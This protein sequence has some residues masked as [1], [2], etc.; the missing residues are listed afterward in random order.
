MTSRHLCAFVALLFPLS[1]AAAT[2]TLSPYGTWV[3]LSAK[4]S[5]SP[6]VFEGLP[7]GLSPD[8]I[9]VR[10]Q[11]ATVTS[12]KVL[13][14]KASSE[15]GNQEVLDELKSL[16]QEKA[17]LEALQSDQSHLRS[18]LMNDKW[19]GSAEEALADRFALITERL[20]AL[21][22]EMAVAAKA[23]EALNDKIRALEILLAPA[24]RE[25]TNTEV[26]V[27][28]SGARAEG[29]VT[30]RFPLRGVRHQFSHKIDLDTVTGG[31][32]VTPSLVVSNR[33]GFDLDD[34]RISYVSKP[35]SSRR[36]LPLPTSNVIQRQAPIAQAKRSNFAGGRAM[37][38]MAM[39][40][41]EVAR[42]AAA[43]PAPVIDQ[44]GVD[45]TWQFAEKHTL[46]SGPEEVRL[47]WPALRSDAQWHVRV[48][49][50]AATEGVIYAQWILDQPIPGGAAVIHRD[51]SLLFERQ[52]GG[53]VAGSKIVQSFGVDPAT[54]VQLDVQPVKV[55]Q[56]ILGT[57]N[58][59]S[60]EAAVHIITQRPR[61]IRVLWALPKTVED[62]VTLAWRGDQ[63]TLDETEGRKNLW[64]F[65]KSL[66]EETP[67]TLNLSFDV[68]APS[69][70]TLV[71]VHF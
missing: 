10:A 52:V 13:P 32:T 29:R 47:W 57:R 60:V 23:E 59:H 31:V 8:D 16:K 3:E 22:S 67:L 61:D 15:P 53:M 51:G 66:E 33:S 42:L 50:Q 28:V 71:G 48:V 39:M 54:R 11:G 68:Q 41:E 5:S 35:P 25:Q 69:D 1:G 70:W 46:L 12:I 38:D 37:A 64:T 58:T 55:D 30:A 18:L 21:R 9:D 40:S 24:P 20:G 4:A 65:S 56:N 2:L 6:V 62:D 63:P 7:A 36:D 19:T 45:V 17:A 26:R 34:V 14:K 27:D 43:P 44:S 49:P